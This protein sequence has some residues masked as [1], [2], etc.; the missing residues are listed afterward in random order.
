[1]EDRPIIASHH[2]QDLTMQRHTF[3]STDGKEEFWKRMRDTKEGWLLSS[4]VG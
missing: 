4:N 3:A 1:M 2:R